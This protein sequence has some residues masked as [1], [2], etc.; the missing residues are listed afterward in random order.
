VLLALNETFRVGLGV[1]ALRE[2]AAELGSDVPFFVYQSAA[3]CRGRGEIVQPVAF[4]HTVPLLLLK[5][6]F[7]VPTP[8]AYKHW[9]N[10]REL[11]G[12][13][14]TPQRFTWGELVNDLERPVFE[15][16]LL[17]AELKMWL[18]GRK[19]V[20]GALLSGSGS[21]TVAILRDHAEAEAIAARAREDFG[22][23]WACPC[24]TR[25]SAP[26]LS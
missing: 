3:V 13:L 21:T 24:V 23:L 1:E 19:E 14:Y 4:A 8:W 18:L 15:K 22:E 16:Y 20:A 6:P 2:L 5:P 25:T 10:S 11:P 17:L 26:G 7:P 9:A 12:V